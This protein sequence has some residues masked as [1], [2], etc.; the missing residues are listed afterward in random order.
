M[1]LRVIRGLVI[2][3]RTHVVFSEFYMTNDHYFLSGPMRYLEEKLGPWSWATDVQYC[4]ASQS[5]G[6]LLGHVCP[7]ERSKQKL[8]IWDQSVYCRQ[9][10]GRF[11][12]ANGIAV[13]EDRL[14][15]GDSKNGTLTIYKLRDDHGGE[16]QDQIV[17]NHKGVYF[18]LALTVDL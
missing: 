5:V 13:W 6:V 9:V 16:F 4:N 11:P 2:S 14:F 15:V 17:R 8:K 3:S 18:R 7:M 10:T 12:G 1:S